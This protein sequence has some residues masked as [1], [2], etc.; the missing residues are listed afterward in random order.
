MKARAEIAAWRRSRE[1]YPDFEAELAKLK[2]AVPRA[3][4]EAADPTMAVC[5]DYDAMYRR[6]LSAQ[7]GKATK[8]EKMLRNT[9]EWRRKTNLEAKMRVWRDIPDDLREKTYVGYQSGWYSA[10]TALGCR[11]TSSAPGS[12]TSRACSSTSPQTRSWTTTCA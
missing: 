1:E 5:G 11:C 4:V 8:A 3:T 10:H 12:C 6:F 2:A 9:V 7:G